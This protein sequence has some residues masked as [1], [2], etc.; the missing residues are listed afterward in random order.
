MRSYPRAHPYYWGA[1]LTALIVG[2]TAAASPALS[3]AVQTAKGVAPMARQNLPST[4]Y[5]VLIGLLAALCVLFLFL[6]RRM[7]ARYRAQGQ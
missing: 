4:P 2:N 5:W 3:A 7:Q 6:Y 1:L